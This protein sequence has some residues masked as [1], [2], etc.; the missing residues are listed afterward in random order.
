LLYI[1]DY[2]LLKQALFNSYKELNKNKNLIYSTFSYIIK[3]SKDKMP[4]FKNNLLI[5]VLKEHKSKI[6]DKICDNFILNNKKN[7]YG[8]FEFI[9]YSN[10]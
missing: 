7:E 9:I 8:Y 3:N 5:S 1:N 2:L 10:I 4:N 6:V